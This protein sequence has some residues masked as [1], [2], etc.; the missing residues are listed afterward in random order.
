MRGHAL[1]CSKKKLERTALIIEPCFTGHHS[2]YLHWIIPA[3][4][5]E[6]FS[7]VLATQKESLQH[8]G[9]KKILQQYGDVLEFE[10]IPGRIASLSWLPWPLRAINIVMSYWLA[11][12]ATYL[13]TAHRR[14]IDMVV[15]PYLDYCTYALALLGSPFQSTRWCG[16]V[17]R[18]TFHYRSSGVH[19]PYS[20]LDKAKEYLFRRLC[21]ISLGKV[22]TIDE[23]LYAALRAE[24]PNAAKRI[25]YLPDP[26]R[27]PAKTDRSLARSALG[28]ADDAAVII[29]FGSLTARKGVAE[30]LHAA[31]AANFPAHAHLLFAGR[32]D[33]D[34]R[35]LLSGALGTRLRSEG[36]LHEMNH[37][38]TAEEEA[39]IFAVSDIVWLG[40]VEHYQMSGVL[41]QAGA[42]GLPVIACQDGLIGWL[43]ARHRTGIIVQVQYPDKVAA[44]IA[45]LLSLPEEME[46][47]GKNGRIAYAEHTTGNAQAILRAAVAV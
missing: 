20:Y 40:Y 38:L 42:M 14:K 7:V 36:R 47:L 45:Q 27:L 28:I 1:S 46:R 34:V 15:L 10:I 2:A 16:I 41:V 4:V 13:R 3:L 31:N 44:A 22:L 29:C 21:G 11:F 25:E 18:P 39:L 37:Y 35:V 6:R 12:R 9:A 33:N 19:A 23:T 8:P 17:M 32:Q 5:L 30:L 43:T 24:T 26:V